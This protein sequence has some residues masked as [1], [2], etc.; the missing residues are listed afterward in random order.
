MKRVVGKILAWIGGITLFI[1]GVLVAVAL[2]SGGE[3]AVPEATVLTL[4]LGSELPEDLP[5]HVL[6]RIAGSGQLT[7]REVVETLERAAEDERVVGLVARVGRGG[8]GFAKTQEI[9][10]AVRFFAESGKPTAAFSESFGEFGPGTGSYYLATGF[11]RIYLQPTGYVGLIGL[12]AQVPFYKG[13][14]DKLGVVPRMGNRKEYKT[15]IYPLTETAFPPAQR[16]ALDS[17]LESL[18][19]QIVHGIAGARG[20]TPDG[21]RAMVD[22]G[23]L[24]AQEALEVGLVDSL[25]YRDQVLDDARSWA[26]H[27]ELLSLS[28]YMERTEESV[29]SGHTVALIYGVG[30]VTGGKSR[31]NPLSGDGTMGS[32]TVTRAFRAAVK[33]PGVKAI[34]F[35]VDSPG[36]SYVAS[37][38][39]WRETVRA[40]EAGKPVIVSM[41]NVAGSG[42][43]FVAM[44]ADRIV[45]QPGT[46]TGS[47]GVYGGKLVVSQ[48]SEKLG[49]T[50]DETHVGENATM[51]S[52]VQDFTPEQWQKFQ[53]YLDRIYD[54]VTSRVAK[55]RGLSEEQTE[56][57]AKGRVWTGEDAFA[58][59]LVDTLGGFQ[60]AKVLVRETLGL[61]PGALLTL[62]RFPEKKSLVELVLDQ[63]RDGQ[64]ALGG[65]EVL[66]R[67]LSRSGIWRMVRAAGGDGSGMLRMPNV[68]LVE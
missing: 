60:V 68:E 41:G 1:A 24:A 11:D 3:D 4:D 43:Y 18:F 9:R 51:W 57:A 36:G 54:D 48:L 10:D 31:N 30:E 52:S 20:L 19:S 34:L 15:G 64:D 65:M 17:L 8:L 23:P 50:W 53:V 28:Q 67:M 35:R 32:D 58:R 49:I 22:Q 42:G 12:A 56:S 29:A 14:L 25:A 47:I 2:I 66:V 45:A 62:K 33:D 44:A 55:A 40:K 39:I 61:S 27:A 13:A 6:A 46:L 5:D 37:D 38:V 16:E 59:G 7:V 26:A 21:V 63:A